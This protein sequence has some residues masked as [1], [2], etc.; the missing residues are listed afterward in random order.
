MRKLMQRV[1]VKEQHYILASKVT[2]MLSTE[3]LSLLVQ[4]VI[5]NFSVKEYFLGCCKLDN[6]KCKHAVES[7]KVN[8][9]CRKNYAIT[10]NI[11]YITLQNTLLRLNLS[12]NYTH[13]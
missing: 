2:G 3:L 11:F 9:H 7:I 13:S 5:S 1:E 6:V 4:Q 10:S 12:L 8:A